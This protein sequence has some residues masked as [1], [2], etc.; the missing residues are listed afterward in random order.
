MLLVGSRGMHP[1]E[2][3]LDFYSMRSPFVGFSV[4]QSGYWPDF[5]LE[6]FFSWEI[7]LENSDQLQTGVDP[8]LQYQCLSISR[9]PQLSEA[10]LRTT[11]SRSGFYKKNGASVGHYFFVL[12]NSFIIS[13][14]MFSWQ[15][16]YFSPGISW[17]RLEFFGAILFSGTTNIY[18]TQIWFILIHALKNKN[19]ICHTLYISIGSKGALEM[20]IGPCI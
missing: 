19:L 5:N 2:M 15:V 6:S 14:W 3:F 1:T 4:I 16:I 8:C 9:L 12:S 13:N 10:Q 7:Y 17:S 18:Y 20:S 11:V